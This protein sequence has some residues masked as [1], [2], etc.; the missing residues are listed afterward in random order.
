MTGTRIARIDLDAAAADFLVAHARHNVWI[1]SFSGLALIVLALYAV[2]SARRAA[3]L[4]LSR[5]QLQHLAQL[6]QMAATLAHEIRNPLGAVK[7]FVQLAAEQQGESAQ[8]LLTPAVEEIQRIE[9]LVN[10]L[11]LYGRPPEPHPRPSRWPEIRTRLLNRAR[12][13]P[14]SGQV[15]LQIASDPLE[16]NTDP[17]LLEQILLN[18]LRNAFEAAAVNPAPQVQLGV[19]VDARGGVTLTVVDNGPGIPPES[20]SR[21]FQPFFTTKSSGTGLGLVIARSLTT[22][23]GGELTLSDASPRGTVAALYF[24]AAAARRAE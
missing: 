5:L 23:L 13:L 14:L 18:L 8:D 2:W 9:R 22:A 10:D 11:L 7:G 1:S 21:L 3:R 17:A 24:P 6:G 20:R 4:E 12:Q 19:S 16:W 15:E